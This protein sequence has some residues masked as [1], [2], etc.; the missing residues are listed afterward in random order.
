MLE[1]SELAVTNAIIVEFLEIISCLFIC[2]VL[3]FL[4]LDLQ[5]QIAEFSGQFHCENPSQ[6]WH[7]YINIYEDKENMLSIL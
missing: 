7:N 2:I 4:F 3:S 6:T 5:K 1:D